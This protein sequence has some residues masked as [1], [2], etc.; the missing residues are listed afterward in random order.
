MGSS[1]N[2]AWPLRRAARM[3]G[4]ST[5]VVDVAGGVS[6]TYAELAARVAARGRL[7]VAEGERVGVLAANSLAHLE[8]FL[9]VPAAG[10][11]IVSLNTRLAPDELRALVADAGLSVLVHDDG[12]ASV[13]AALGVARLLHVDD[14][15]AT[16]LPA[17]APA[18]D[19]DALAAISFTG[20]TTGRAKGVMLSHGN[21]L[22]NAR[23][24]LIATG[25]QDSDRWLHVCPMFHAAGIANVVAATWVGAH[26]V[27]LPRFD[28][29]AFCAAV[30]E[31]AITHVALV[32]T[33][34]G[35]LLDHLAN[36]DADLSSLRH[37][38]YAASPITP[39]LQR[40]VLERFAGVDVAQF[41]GMTEA[42]PTVSTCTP[43]DHRR[44]DG[45]RLGSIGAPVVGVEAEV[46]DAESG[47][48]L[49]VGEIGELWVRGPN[50]M[51][52]YFNQPDATAAALQDGWYRTGD[53]AR[54]DADGYL[55]LVDRL[56]DMIISGGENVYSVEVEAVLAEHPAVA[57][58]AVFGVPDERWG[59]AVHA[60]VSVTATD[61]EV[62]PAELIAHC[63][64][65][66]AGFK[67]PRAIEITEAPL[68][69]SGAGKLL[70]HELRAP[71]WAGRER[72]IS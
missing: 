8:L 66:I 20:G 55:Y 64:A 2:L 31:H 6:V 45:A 17:A 27:V 7:G 44:P 36:H 34:L 48:P 1:E 18:P 40:R 42:A 29:A 50:V 26:Q 51:L 28:A 70:K 49:P 52:G 16:P 46:R 39:D 67:V 54:A 24:N 65:S 41:Y 43:A 69:K 56:K 68:P 63:R 15:P 59:E 71:F 30:E 11:V 72:N 32:P 62:T 12:H 57:E 38:Q 21:L 58:V 25:H 13:A 23:H 60:V 33:M 5:A 14:L 37:I 35:M 61:A 53:A 47:A 10:G 3:H 4:G 19:A 22:A 9:G